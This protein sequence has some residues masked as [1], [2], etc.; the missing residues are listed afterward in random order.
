MAPMLRSGD[1]VG[2]DTA[3]HSQ[4]VD[5]DLYAIRDGNLIRVKQL[6]PRPDGGI[7]IK[8]FNNTDYPDEQLSREEF[9]QRIHIIGRVFWSSTLW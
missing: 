5:G 8:S 1:V 2:I 4:I 7:I 9:E 3:N 6:V